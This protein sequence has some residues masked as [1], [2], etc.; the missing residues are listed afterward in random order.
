MKKENIW[1][2]SRAVRFKRFLR[3][4]YAVFLSLK[5]E[6]N[7]GMLAIPMLAFANVNSVSAQIENHTQEMFYELQEVEV[8]G[9]RVPMALGQAARIVTVLDRDDIA[10]V[11]AQSVNDL[12]KYA[13]GVDVRQRGDMGIQTDISIRG[14]TFDQ[15]TILLNGINICDPQTGHNSADFPVDI[16][17]IERI[18]VLEGPAGRVYGTS[19]LVGA[20]NI[21]TR[22]DAQSGAELHA[23]GGSYGFADAGG[24]VNFTNGALSNQVSGSFTRS[25]GFSRNAAGRLN[26]DFRQGKA[27]YQGQYAHET[28]NVRWHAGFTQKDYGANTFYSSSYDDQFEHTRKYFTAIQAETK[29]G[30]YS[31]KPSAYWNRSY[32]RFELVRN[33]PES[34]PYNY[35]R[36]DVYGLNLNNT[37]ETLLGKTAFGAEFRNEGILS[38]TL[39]ET[40]Q[41]PQ[42]APDGEEYTVGLNRTNLSFHLE[43]NIMLQDF[44]LS[45]GVIAVKNTGNEMNFRFYP[46][47]DASWRF[48]ENW[49]LYASFNTSLRMPTFTELYYSVEG[50]EADKNLKPEEMKAY[51]AGMKYITPAIQ[52]TASIYH[53]RGTN[54]IDWIKDLS[55]GDDA[56][57]QSVNHAKVNTTGIETSMKMDFDELLHAH[58]PLSSLS[59]S[60]AYI[61]QDKKTEENL[62]SRYTLEYLRHKVVAQANLHVW[63]SL[64]LHV[65]YRWQ[66][67]M[68]NY[69]SDGQTVPYRPY[70]LLDARLSWDTPDYR[71]YAEA[72]NLL[73]KT[74][75]DYGNIPQPGIWLRAGMSWQIRW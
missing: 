55:E 46:G 53:Y 38:T 34:V 43:H 48:A 57:W 62:Q 9:T 25:D 2:L 17:E 39:G 58:T 52:A 65:S 74:Y 67:R 60:Y 73:N 16:S 72:N 14:G 8:T 21:V 64:K 70:S 31:F 41:T 24:H 7:I 42:P 45:A 61:Y 23:E 63:R 29:G 40:L 71:L 18:E 50:Y 54:L 47:I 26:S 27:F 11:P 20:I 44:T 35:N 4:P 56:P 75:Y 13:V 59:L 32:D 1:L 69:E 30:N 12:L 68:G 51:E 22:T 5:V 15:I 3:R 33:H 36:T 10:A 19:S 6:V 37:L 66:D 28:V 49:K